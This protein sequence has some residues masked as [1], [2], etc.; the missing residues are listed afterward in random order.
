MTTQLRIDQVTL[1]NGC[2]QSENL[3]ARIQILLKAYPAIDF[4]WSPLKTFELVNE[5]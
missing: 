5:N 3:N 2:I 1:C 4:K